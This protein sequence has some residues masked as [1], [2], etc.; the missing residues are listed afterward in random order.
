MATARIKGD[1]ECFYHLVSR[2]AYQEFKFGDEAKSMF[3]SMLMRVA[4][5]SGVEVLN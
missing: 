3:V 2:T 1:G 5:F 4:F